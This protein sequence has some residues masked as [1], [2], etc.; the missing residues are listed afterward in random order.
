MKNTT[1][2]FLGYL[3]KPFWDHVMHVNCDPGAMIY[4]YKVSAQE[5]Y[6]NSEPASLIPKGP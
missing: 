5:L 1:H 6:I 3:L 2:Q 4:S